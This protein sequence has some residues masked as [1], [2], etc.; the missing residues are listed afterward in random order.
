M[1]KGKARGIRR[2]ET[3]EIAEGGGKKERR[4]GTRENKRTFIEVK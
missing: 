2:V 4:G 1:N 3:E